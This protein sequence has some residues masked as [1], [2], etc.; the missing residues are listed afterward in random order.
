MTVILGLSLQLVSIAES[1]S[2]K[3]V[4]FANSMEKAMDCAVLGVDVYECAPELNRDMY[5]ELQDELNDTQ[6]VLQ[7]MRDLARTNSLEEEETFYLT[8]EEY[9]LYLELLEEKESQL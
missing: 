6:E 8:E 4:D 1:T 7:R 5:F 9:Q 2:D 3:V